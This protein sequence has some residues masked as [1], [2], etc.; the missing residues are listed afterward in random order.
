M[1]G[2]TEGTKRKERTN[3]DLRTDEKKEEKAIKWKVYA[4]LW[5]KYKY[6]Y[7]ESILLIA[8]HYAWH[9]VRT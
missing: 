8:G 2:W 3:D 5:L 7:I 6:Y 4:F 1:V 9:K